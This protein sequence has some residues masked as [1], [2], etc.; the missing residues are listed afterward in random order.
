VG[1]NA[2]TLV[3][4]SFDGGSAPAGWSVEQVSGS[5]LANFVTTSNNPSGFTPVNGTH[6]VRFD[7]YNISSGV[8]S[9][10][11]QTSAFSTVGYNTV[12]VDFQWLESSGFSGNNDRVEVQWSTNG[13]TWNTAATIS[14]Y[15]AVQGWKTKT[16]SLPAGAEGQA[17]LYV[18]FLFTSA[19]GN[20]CFLD[21][22]HVTAIAPPP[23][24]LS[25]WAFALIGVALLSFIVFKFRK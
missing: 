22:A 15:N 5:G 21:F 18:A 9:R 20:S 1:L 10:V 3:T 12:A 14:R 24:P 2:Q 8:S 16:V 13:T 19:Y 25:N 7:S 23:V 4:Q 17:N 6:M 11:K